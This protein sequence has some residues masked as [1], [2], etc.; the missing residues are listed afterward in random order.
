LGDR[1]TTTRLLTL[2]G[3]G[4]CGKT[5]LALEVAADAVA[6]FPDDVWLV[7]LAALSD[8]ALIAKA[9]ATAIG[10]RE[11]ADRPVRETLLAALQT[12]RLL[13]VVDNCEHLREGCAA[14]ALVEALAG[15]RAAGDAFN[16][17]MALHH[18]GLL[19]LEAER[20][21]DTCW[22]LNEESLALLRAVGDRRMIG[23]TLQAMGRAARARGDAASAR[24]L[25]GEALALHTQV[26]DFGHV[27][28]MLYH[29]AAICAE[30]GALER[31]VRVAASASKMSEE[32]GTRVWPVIE[33]ERDAWL[34]PARETL[35]DAH[36][37]LASSTT[38][39]CSPGWS[40]TS[41]H[42]NRQS[43]SASNSSASQVPGSSISPAW[44]R[45]RHVRRT[46]QT[47]NGHAESNSRRALCEGDGRHAAVHGQC[48]R[49]PL[50][51]SNS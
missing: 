47:M 44:R 25:I 34:E 2:T 41:T 38:H 27:P 29:L 35:G 33:R 3:T 42:M 23:V 30:R 8:P 17:A 11:A 5:R 4:G 16:T 9:V 50:A 45:R 40:A 7:E 49:R 19:A 31:A 36:F 22:T 51:R 13:L 6:A 39:P 20:D 37:A 26:G 1:L 12:R 14:L 28:Q 10:L 48:S 32:M 46:C 15:A 18:L 21:A 24:A 43:G